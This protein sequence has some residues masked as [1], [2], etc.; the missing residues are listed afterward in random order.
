M[1]ELG[2]VATRQVHLDWFQLGR[3]TA[4]TAGRIVRW[5]Q[6][7]GGVGLTVTSTVS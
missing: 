2:V 7:C 6:S 4:E 3:L 5:A 1:L